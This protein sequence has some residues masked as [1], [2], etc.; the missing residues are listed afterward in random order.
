MGWS[1]CCDEEE[2]EAY[3]GAEEY[4]VMR[5]DSVCEVWVDIKKLFTFYVEKPTGNL[6][7]YKGCP[8]KF[9]EHLISAAEHEL[10][11]LNKVIE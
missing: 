1:D 10:S 9:W 2:P 3:D 5:D 7:Y 11:E 8:K 6:I 4:D